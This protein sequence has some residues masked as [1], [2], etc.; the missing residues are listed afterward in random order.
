MPGEVDGIPSTLSKQK[1]SLNVPAMLSA[2]LPL[3][4]WGGGSWVKDYCI[5]CSQ[6][7]PPKV[8]KGR[9]PSQHF[10]KDVSFGDPGWS[11]RQKHPM[12]TSCFLN[13]SQC[14]EVPGLG[15]GAG[16]RGKGNRA[17]APKGKILSGG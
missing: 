15:E 1:F 3:A 5:T 7:T 9:C 6:A 2:A 13:M 14:H 12:L 17:L 8:L 16:G 4:G 11:L 10:V